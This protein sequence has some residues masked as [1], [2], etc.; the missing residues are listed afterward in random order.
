VRLHIRYILM[1][2]M[3][4]AGLSRALAA[5]PD[6]IE[7][8]SEKIKAA[9]DNPQLLVERAQLRSA[10]GDHALAIAD[11]DRALKLEPARV[12]WVDFRGSEQLLAGNIAAAIADFDRYL[13]VHPNQAPYHWKRGIALYYAGRYDDGVKQ[14]DLHQTV[15][16]ADVENAVWRYL[17]MAK[18]DGVAAAQKDLLKIGRDT[19][20]PM[21]EVYELFGGNMKAD[22]VLKA[23]KANDPA[24]ETLRTRLFYAHLYLG[25]Y[26]DAQGNARSAF[27]HMQQ[28]VDKYLVADYMGGIAKVHYDLLKKNP[29]QP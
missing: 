19:R 7:A 3:M 1:I 12:E 29:P 15:N 18:R 20:V 14:F 25:L 24:A 21:A 10:G 16:S 13:A 17:C 26:F 11:L 2:G 6:A 27:E 23:A 5:E 28:A 4:A 9:P 8:I 22:D